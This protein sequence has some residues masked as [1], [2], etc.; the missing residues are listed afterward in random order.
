VGLM[1]ER[2]VKVF[3]ASGAIGIA[4]G[5]LLWVFV[6]DVRADQKKNRDEHTAMIV[7]QQ[8]ISRGMLKLADKSGETQRLQ[9]KIL[10][11]IRQMCVQG[12]ETAS[13]RRECLR[14]Q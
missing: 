7:E 5:V 4:F 13:D 8:N 10:L 6:V 12:A 3:A 2:I 9:E 1:N 14:E 11:V